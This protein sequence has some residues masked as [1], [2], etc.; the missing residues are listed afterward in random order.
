MSHRPTALATDPDPCRH[1][2]RSRRRADGAP[3][4]LLCRRE[5]YRALTP[6]D[7]AQLPGAC[8]HGASDRRTASGEPLCA[9]CKR[10][11]GPS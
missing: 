10:E 2:A 6:A 9:L 3:A 11:G 7:L 4:C 8:R 5:E 1:G